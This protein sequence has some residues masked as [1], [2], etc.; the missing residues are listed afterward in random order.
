MTRI[1][2]TTVVYA[3]TYQTK[4]AIS[5]RER[6]RKIGRERDRD[7]QTDRQT[8]IQTSG[9]HIPIG[10]HNVIIV[11]KTQTHVKSQM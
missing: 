3:W 1:T 10:A 5:E 9:V 7:R 8:E 11:L 2:I 6:E 4:I